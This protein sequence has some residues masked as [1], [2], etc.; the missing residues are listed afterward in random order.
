MRLRQKAFQS[1]AINNQRSAVARNQ[2]LFLEA[3]QLLSD[4][5]PG[6]A[7]Q[8]SDIAMT[9]GQGQPDSFWI[10]D[11]E[12]FTQFQQDQSEALLQTAAHEI[13][14]AQVNQIPATKI[15]L[16][17]PLEV[18]GRDAQRYFDQRLEFDGPDSA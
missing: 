15:A 4:S 7:Y 16:R 12:V 3:D 11:A 13:C 6:G 18:D 14:A 17:H 5:R 10:R 1:V 2:M 9:G 8:F